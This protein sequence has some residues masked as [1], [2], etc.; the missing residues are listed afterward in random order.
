[1]RSSMSAGVKGMCRLLWPLPHLVI[2]CGGNRGN[3][4]NNQGS[5]RVV[6]EVAIERLSIA[7]VVMVM[8]VDKGLG[9]MDTLPRLFDS[10]SES[11][12]II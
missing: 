4:G 9:M 11:S 3:R 8:V 6:V 2:A 12:A 7:M 5:W 1:M 10:L